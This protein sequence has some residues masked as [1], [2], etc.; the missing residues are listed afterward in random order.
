M[1]NRKSNYDITRDRVEG[2]FPQYDQ[3]TVIAKF[4][5]AHDGEYI[6]LRFAARDYRI[7]RKTGRIERMPEPLRP[8]AAGY[9][10]RGAGRAVL[11]P[12]WKKSGSGN[13][14]SKK[15][16]FSVNTA[17]AEQTVQFPLPIFIRLDMQARPQALEP[18][19]ADG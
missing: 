12:A 6:C 16:K 3:E 10:C 17:G 9:D 11:Y 2:E 19:P 7:S 1:E 8:G 15:R 14:I 18:V 5:L 4:H 13:N